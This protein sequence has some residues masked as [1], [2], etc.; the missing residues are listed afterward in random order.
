[1]CDE[2]GRY[3]IIFIGAEATQFGVHHDGHCVVG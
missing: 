3:F 1:V 2:D